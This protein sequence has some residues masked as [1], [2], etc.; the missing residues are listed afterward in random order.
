MSPEFSVRVQAIVRAIPAGRVCT[1]GHIAELAG[2]PRHARH[3][4][5]LLA[6]MEDVPW[7]RVVGAGGRIARAGSEAADWQR[8]LLE[9]EGVSFCRNGLVDM[10]QCGWTTL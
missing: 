7:Q 1:Y 3:V 9:H 5:R 10:L 8:L 4:G 6:G 2:F